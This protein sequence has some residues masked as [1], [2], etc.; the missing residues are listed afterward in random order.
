[1]RPFTVGII[2]CG[3]AG[4]H[5]ARAFASQPGVAVTWAIDLR[6]AQAQAVANLLAGARVS[7]DYHEA[8][9]D[10]DLDAVDI[11]LPHHLHA[12]VS[13]EAIARGKHVLCEKPLAATLPQAD[14]MIAAAEKAGLTLM[15]A[16]NEVFSPLYR[17][18]R[19]LIAADAIGKPAL[20]Q[21]TRGCFLEESFKKERPW[22]LDEQAAAG[23]MMM[24]GGVH[25]FEKLRMIIGEVT[26]VF[27]R[28]APQRFV[29]MQGDDTSVA[30]LRFTSGAIGL[31]VQSFL[32]KNA[33]TRSGVEE[34]TLRI[35]GESGSILAAGTNGGRIVLFR[36]SVAD[37]LLADLPVETEML[38]P[39][40]DT[41]E[42]ETA[43]FV[44][45]VRD[46]KE[47]ITAARKMRR[48]LALVLAAY[49]SMRTNREVEV[50][51]E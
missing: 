42:L 21:M 49:E 26:A 27:A 19:D 2:G 29:G 34:H 48:P 11:C 40:L 35:E 18:V 45:C 51:P 30:M 14:G 25:D 47:P 13:V 1:M 41:F 46:G 50:P 3:W 23:G 44:A 24:S 9:E 33:L 10:R 31:M 5:H 43:H 16:E 28:R 17:R 8:L 22:F 39:E 7:A 6:P 4:A 12:R 20:V 15:V 36:D 32:M 38:I 37:R